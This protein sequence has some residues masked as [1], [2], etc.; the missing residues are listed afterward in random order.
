MK[1]MIRK[2]KKNVAR[3]K[4]FSFAMFIF[5]IIALLAFAKLASD[6]FIDIG[7]GIAGS[8]ILPAMW[9]F[10]FMAFCSFDEIEEEMEQKNG[11]KN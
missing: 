1:K 5:G 2:T 6:G 4:W 9:M 8:I 7:W 11:K 10:W 3:L